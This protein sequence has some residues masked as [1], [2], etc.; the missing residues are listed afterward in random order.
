[1]LAKKQERNGWHIRNI[2]L[3][4]YEELLRG[5]TGKNNIRRYVY[6]LISATPTLAKPTSAVPWLGTRSWSAPSL[7]AS[8]ALDDPPFIW[9]H[10][11]R[12]RT[13]GTVDGRKH[14]DARTR[15]QHH[16]LAVP[17]E[18][19]D[20]AMGVPPPPCRCERALCCR[21]LYAR[22]RPRFALS[23]SSGG[24][25]PRSA[26]MLRV[27]SVVPGGCGVAILWRLYGDE[28]GPLRTSPNLS[29]RWFFS[30]HVSRSRARV[31]SCYCT[32]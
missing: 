13:I 22:P 17:H 5:R 15:G 9:Y 19:H 18:T 30:S 10:F 29:L 16:A 31:D 11:D 12:C 32:C 1:M 21:R 8:A 27:G 2:L 4:F 3:R 23:G 25:W 14:P 24:N 28:D 20:V 7:T 6:I 26:Q